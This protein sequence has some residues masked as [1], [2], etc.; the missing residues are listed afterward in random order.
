M[1]QGASIL[2]LG[3]GSGEPIA[4]YFIE[5]GYHLSGIDASPA[6]IGLCTS[7]FPDQNWLVADMRTLA[8]NQ[9]FDGIMA[10]DSFFHLT[11]NDQHRMFPIFK[12]H[13]ASQAA[14]LFT[15]GPAYGEVMGTYKDEPLYH[16]SLD[17][18]EYRSL[19]NENGFD[20]VMHVSEAPT[21]GHHT[22]WLAQLR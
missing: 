4:R 2:D 18:E 20:V 7:R 22:V 21:C 16:A 8:L 19:L 5:Q 13:A 9:R 15:S 1:P 6:F 10:W 12:R 11:H 14:L 3:C 17:G